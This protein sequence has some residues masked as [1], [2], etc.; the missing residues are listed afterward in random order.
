MAATLTTAITAAIMNLVAGLEGIAG[1][2]IVVLDRAGNDP[3]VFWHQAALKLCNR[4]GENWCD[5]DLVSITDTT[6]ALGWSRLITYV[7]RTSGQTKRV[8]LVLPPPVDV[9]PYMAATGLS[10]GG[11]VD[12]LNLPTSADTYTWLTLQAAANCIADADGAFADRRADAFATI[13]TTLIDG[14]P[15]ATQPNGIGPAR[16]FQNF[17]NHDAIRWANDMAERYEFDIWKNQV[18]LKAPSMI[19]CQMTVVPNTDLATDAI[20]RDPAVLPVDGCTGYAG[21]STQTAR[22][23]DANLYAWMYASPL[24]APPQAWQPYQGFTDFNSAT[25]WTWTTASD[26]AKQYTQ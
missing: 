22:V 10:K 3:S 25:Q 5:S 7:G 24:G 16:L 9:S 6:A 12:V 11:Y 19:G 1:Y 20:V 21:G 23:T 2:P 26:L 17:R 13:A 18:A 15:I 8:C 4:T 14:D